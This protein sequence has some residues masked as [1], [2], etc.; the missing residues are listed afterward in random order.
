[1]VADPFPVPISHLGGPRF[2]GM[3][4]EAWQQLAEYSPAVSILKAED[5]RVVWVSR[6]LLRFYRMRAED[7]IGKTPDEFTDSESAALAEKQHREALAA[8]VPIRCHVTFCH[9]DGGR[10]HGAGF[11]FPLTGSDGRRYVAGVFVDVTDLVRTREQLAAREN[12]FRAVFERAPIGMA[13]TDLSGRIQEING[14]FCSL[15]GVS[16]VSVR[17]LRVRELTPPEERDRERELVEALLAGERAA[18][19]LDK[20]LLRPGDGARVPVTLHASLIRDVTGRPEAALDIVIPRGEVP[21][22]RLPLPE[23]A[24]RVLELLALGHTTRHI[25][26][27]IGCAERTAAKYVSQLAVLLRAQSRAEIVARAYATGLLRPGTWPPRCAASASPD[28]SFRR[29]G[30]RGVHA[31]LD[32]VRPAETRFRRAMPGTPPQ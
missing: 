5:G 31:D 2:S 20:H 4:E 10:G 21:A 12:R 26:R 1:M 25:A 6:S 32:Q 13:I 7:L 22:R 9:P 17:G 27:R 24:A 19:R 16:A 14:T 23:Q 3:P 8:G 28:R 29:E 11:R 15:L 18:F 30:Q